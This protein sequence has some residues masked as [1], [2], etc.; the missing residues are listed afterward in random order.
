MIKSMT[1]FGRSEVAADDKKIIIEMKSVNH[2]Y[3][4][5]NIKMP[6]KFNY[7][8]NDI[9]NHMKKYV[10]R[11]K[12]DVFLTYENHRQS[13]VSVKYNNNIAKEYIEYF[14]HM[15][16]EFDIPNNITTSILAKMQDVF[17]LEEISINE[18]GIWCDIEKALDEAGLMFVASRIA[19]GE[20][21]MRDMISKLDSMYE[22][23]KVIE[24]KSP[25]IVAYHKKK[26]TDKVSEIIGAA[27]IDE[28]RLATEIVIFADKV[29]VDEEIVRLKSHIEATKSILLKGGSVGRKL[30]F[31]AQEMNREAN[32]ILSKASSLEVT[33]I[34]IEIKTDIEKVREQIQN[35]E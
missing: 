15:N 19:E 26:L 29:S 34:S 13:N 4:D 27:N 7:F 8:E 22:M 24:E 20:N 10:Q 23:V 33:D 32:T 30:D 1:G 31:L 18:E 35:I 6:R 12:V 2:R 14:N 25:L 3:C 11:G 5:M 28:N 21:L 17:V 9:R 16:E